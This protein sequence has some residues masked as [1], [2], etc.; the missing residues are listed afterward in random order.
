MAVEYGLGQVYMANVNIDGSITKQSVNVVSYLNNIVTVD[1]DLTVQS[2]G[3]YIL[4][5]QDNEDN[6]C[7]GKVTGLRTIELHEDSK[8]Y[9]ITNGIALKVMKG[10]G[11]A[12]YESAEISINE[13]EVSYTGA[14]KY[15]RASEATQADGTVTLTNVVFTNVFCEIINGTPT[16]VFGDGLVSNVS[17]FNPSTDYDVDPANLC[18]IFIK[19]TKDDPTKMEEFFV[20]RARCGNLNLPLQREAFYVSTYTFDIMNKS[21]FSGDMLDYTV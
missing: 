1:A 12:S 5:H 7:F 11:T 16:N 4:A 19:R 17:D 21:M 2:I 9:F 10:M 18:L 6:Y 8:D 15:A 3:K 20:P 14:Y 13:S